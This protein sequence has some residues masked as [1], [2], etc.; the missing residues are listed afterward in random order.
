MK[1]KFMMLSLLISGPQ[2]PGNDIDVYLSPLIEDLQTLWDV[3]VE[4]YDAYRNEFFN[5]RVVLLWTIND[6]PAYKKLVGCIV[7]GYNACPYCGVDTTKCRL[8][9]SGK[10]AY[11]RHCRWLPHDHEFHDQYKAFDNTIEREFALQPL[12]SEVVLGLVDFINYKWGKNKS[13]KCKSSVNDDRIWW[14]NIYIF[15]DLEY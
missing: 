10:N 2:Q 15:Y 4:A 8:K 1:Q 14:K 7:K 5:M 13:L 11:I 6:L 3:G 12:N 9:H